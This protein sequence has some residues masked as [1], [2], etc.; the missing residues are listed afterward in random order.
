MCVCAHV[1][2]CMCTCMWCVCLYV[3]VFLFSKNWLNVENLLSLTFYPV[4]CWREKKSTCSTLNDFTL[5]ASVSPNTSQ[6]LKKLKMS[7]SFS[8]WPGRNKTKQR[9]KQVVMLVLHLLEK[10]KKVSFPISLAIFFL[11][12][13]QP[14]YSSYLVQARRCSAVCVYQSILTLSRGMLALVLHGLLMTFKTCDLWQ[15]QLMPTL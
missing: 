10:E 8:G 2:M 7:T 4:N 15:R 3:C 1:C 5:V 12:V 14:S 9:T 11:I 13:Y 6:I